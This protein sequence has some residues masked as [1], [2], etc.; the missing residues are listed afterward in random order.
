VVG[1]FTGV[2]VLVTLYT[3]EVVPRSYDGQPRQAIF[4]S[5]A[6]VSA[7]MAAVIVAMIRAR[8]L[9]GVLCLMACVLTLA[10][11]A[12]VALFFAIPMMGA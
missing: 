7:T 5:L 3:V 11:V 10:V 2:L 9:R 6:E 4:V 1:V 8:T 12:V